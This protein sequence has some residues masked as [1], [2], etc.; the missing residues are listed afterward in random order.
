M[1]LLL[2]VIVFLFNEKYSF[3]IQIIPRKV[4]T[5]HVKIFRNLKVQMALNFIS[6]LL[7]EPIEEQLKQKI[8]VAYVQ[9]VTF[10]WIW[11]I[12]FSGGNLFFGIMICIFMLLMPYLKLLELEKKLRKEMIESMNDI[13]L[14]VAL[15]INAGMVVYNALL[16]VIESPQNPF[17]SMYLRKM[18]MIRKGQNLSTVL[19]P[20]GQNVYNDYV[21]RFI[22]IIISDQKSGGE[23]TFQSL[24]RL[25]DDFRKD[26]HQQLLKKGEEAS[27]KLLMP[28][29]IALIG[30]VI[31]LVYPAVIS[32]MQ[33]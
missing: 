7:E 30:I 4:K 5:S 22:R 28:M 2:Y 15:N 18:N 29:S 16:D 33:F 3:L 27:T 23:D 9:S 1:L 10:L 19:L 32:L 26:R 14:S 17:E 31:A 11:L 24:K 8:T 20:I 12:Q 6:F 13:F 25:M 21:T